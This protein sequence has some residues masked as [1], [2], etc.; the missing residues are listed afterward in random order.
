MLSLTCPADMDRILHSPIRAGSYSFAEEAQ[1]LR[2]P[3]RVNGGQPL[4]VRYSGQHQS[5]RLFVGFGLSAHLIQLIT[6]NEA[7]NSHLASLSA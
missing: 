7:R 2:V 3:I 6:S 4:A 5:F 1:V